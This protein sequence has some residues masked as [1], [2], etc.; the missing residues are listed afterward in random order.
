MVAH[1]APNPED[2]QT[3]EAPKPTAPTE[4]KAEPKAAPKK[5]AKAPTASS[6]KLS[7]EEQVKQSAHYTYLWARLPLDLQ[8]LLMANQAKGHLIIH[9]FSSI[10]KRDFK[11]PEKRKAFEQKLHDILNSQESH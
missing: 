7:F 3:P 9:A 6:K 4:V 10:E 1:P 2:S 5:P 11:N 8:K